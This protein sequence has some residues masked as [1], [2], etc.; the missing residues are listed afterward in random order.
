MLRRW[1]VEKFSF[2]DNIALLTAESHE[3]AMDLNKVSCV[4]CLP[5][6]L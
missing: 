6:F 5:A 3:R 4:V 1:G 2:T